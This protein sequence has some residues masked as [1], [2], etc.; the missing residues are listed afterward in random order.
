MKLGYRNF[1]L[2]D[3]TSRPGQSRNFINELPWIH[4]PDFHRS[5][6]CISLFQLVWMYLFARK[7]IVL[8]P[9]KFFQLP[10]KRKAGWRHYL[11]V[12]AIAFLYQGDLLG[13]FSLAIRTKCFS[14]VNFYKSRTTS[15]CHR[16]G[17][18]EQYR[19]LQRWQ[20]FAFVCIVP[21]SLVLAF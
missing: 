2:R 3:S 10:T 21:E 14:S 9:T 20:L 16:T 12:H 15:D 8:I 4:L 11:S 13:T 17:L 6:S 1:F 18:C 19:K 7:N 5:D